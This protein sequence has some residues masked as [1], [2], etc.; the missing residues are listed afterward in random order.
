[1]FTLS[2]KGIV[3]F[4]G[5]LAPCQYYEVRFPVTEL[6]FHTLLTKSGCQVSFGLMWFEGTAHPCCLF[7][8]EFCVPQDGKASEPMF[9]LPLP[10]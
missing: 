7:T 3:L 8:E 10:C 5:E 4:S 1:M 9:N 2:K 6:S